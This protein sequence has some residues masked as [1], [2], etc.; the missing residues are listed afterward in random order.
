MQVELFSDGVLFSA[1]F[2]FRRIVGTI[3]LESKMYIFSQE[4]FFSVSAFASVLVF[5]VFV[6]YALENIY[7]ISRNSGPK[8][9]VWNG[10]DSFKI[11]PSKCDPVANTTGDEC[12]P[13][14]ADPPSSNIP[15]CCC[16]CP[17]GGPTFAF[18]NNSWACFDNGNIRDL[19]GTVRR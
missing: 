2:A 8:D 4:F 18:L 11:P 3:L 10:K 9:Q 5:H 6:G 16:P 12:E 19:Q 13:F 17:G 7:E 14:R 15:K 1:R